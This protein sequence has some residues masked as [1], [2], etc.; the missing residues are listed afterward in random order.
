L[1]IDGGRDAVVMVKSPKCA[2]R[3]QAITRISV[4]AHLL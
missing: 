2:V 4:T 3:L 1:P